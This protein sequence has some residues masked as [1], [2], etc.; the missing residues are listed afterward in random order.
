ME[1]VKTPPGTGI[2]SNPAL[3]RV[4]KDTRIRISTPG[5]VFTPDLKQTLITSVFSPRIKPEA[6][7]EEDS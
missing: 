4:K 5:R 2:L 1:T 3:G 7:T 6:D